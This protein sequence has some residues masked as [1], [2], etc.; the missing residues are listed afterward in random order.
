MRG[1]QSYVIDAADGK[2]A[3]MRV[4]DLATAIAERMSKENPEAW[5]QMTH[6][7]H[8]T[9]FLKGGVTIGDRT[10]DAY[11]GREADGTVSAKPFIVTSHDPALA[12]LGKA[13]AAQFEAAE[14][15]SPPGVNMSVLETMRKGTPLLMAG[16]E[17]KSI[18]TADVDPVQFAL[19][20][21]VDTLDDVRARLA[22]LQ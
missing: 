5:E 14:K 3:I 22:R 6:L 9:L 11:Y 2:P 16:L 15:M 8:R 1:G 19:P 18:S 12:P 7:P 17:L 4:E 13:M 20:G 21:P 10:G